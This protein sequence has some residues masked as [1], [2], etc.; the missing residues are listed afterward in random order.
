[1]ISVMNHG[2]WVLQQLEL[3]DFAG[4]SAAVNACLEVAKKIQAKMI[5]DHD[6]EDELSIMQLLDMS[7]F[8]YE[9]AGPELDQLFGV[10]YSYRININMSPSLI[11][12]PDDYIS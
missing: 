4:E 9:K 3:H 6:Q 1:M 11:Y 7:S 8:Q 10:Y 2:F 12:N 5:Y